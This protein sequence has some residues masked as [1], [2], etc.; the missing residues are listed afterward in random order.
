MTTPLLKALGATS[1]A[2]GIDTDVSPGLFWKAP[3][4]IRCTPVVKVTDVSP[5]LLKALYLMV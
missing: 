5:V 2:A 4:I 1:V 3:S